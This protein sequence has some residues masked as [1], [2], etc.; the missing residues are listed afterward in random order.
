MADIKEQRLHSLVHK[1]H[2]GQNRRKNEEKTEMEF[3]GLR[4]ESKLGSHQPK[5]GLGLDFVRIQ[6]EI[7]CCCCSI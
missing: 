1:R 6:H 3:T 4:E 7:F 2:W 5:M